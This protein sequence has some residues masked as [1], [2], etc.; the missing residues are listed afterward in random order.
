VVAPELPTATP[1]LV[2]PLPQPLPPTTSLGASTEEIAFFDR[3]RK[4]ISNKAQYGEFLKLINLFT[5]DLCSDKYL[6]YRAQSFIGSSLEL[7]NYFKVFMQYDGSEEIVDNQP[8]NLH[9][10]IQLSNCRGMGP[11]YRL[12]P[13]LEKNKK[14]SGRDALC[15][16]VLN[17]EWVSHP[18]W[19][20]EDSGFVAHRKNAH[21]EGLHRVEEE[22][23]DY[24]FYIEACNRTIQLLEPIAQT[25]NTATPDHRR[26]FQLDPKLGGQSETIYK[27]VVYKIYGRE[28]GN[29]V[30]ENLFNRPYDVVPILLTRLKSKSAEWKAAQIQWERVWRQQTNVLFY[31]S[32][33]HQGVATRVADKRQFWPKQLVNEIQVR[34]QEQKQQRQ[35]RQSSFPTYQ[36]SYSFKD[37]GVLS[38]AARLVLSYADQNFSTD[39]PK[40]VA[41]IKEFLSLFF[42]DERRD[43]SLIFEQE[44]RQSNGSPADGEESLGEDGSSSPRHRANSKKNTLLRGVLDRPR[45]RTGKPENEDSAASDSRGTSPENLSVMDEDNATSPKP[46]DNDVKT[47]SSAK[48]FQHPADSNL[49]NGQTVTPNEQYK[50]QTYNM[51]CNNTIYCFI[52]LFALLYERL[53]KLKANE[54]EVHRIVKR[55]MQPKSAIDLGWIERLPTDFFHDTSE[56]ADYYGQMLETFHKLIKG[57]AE[58]ANIEEALRR[59]YLHDGWQL[60]SLDKLL[61]SLTRFAVAMNTSDA[62]DKSMEIY[63]LFKKDRQR[64]ENTSTQEEFSYRKQ[65]DKH[66][67]EGDV[68]RIAYVSFLVNNLRNARDTDTTQ[69]EKDQVVQIQL[70]K[71]EDPTIETSNLTAAQRWKVYVTAYESLEPT[72]GITY[73]RSLDFPYLRRG[74]R[75]QWGDDIPQVESV[76]D[77]LTSSEN[78][79]FR[80]NHNHSYKID[81]EPSRSE[82]HVYREGKTT[83]AEIDLEATRRGENFQEIFVNNPE[84]MKGQSKD[85]V[86][87]AKQ[88]F[89]DSA[90]NP[91]QLS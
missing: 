52:R 40:I 3:V 51:Y 26:N 44:G 47:I 89:I 38:D 29:E 21:E 41:F 55:A 62:R 56:T 43:E 78:M 77:T 34:Y 68:F 11:S 72:E 27:R 28:K 14:C 76:V 69:D 63:S 31:K 2:P 23:H 30:L 15:N 58:M 66:I 37:S 57:D 80:I 42:L 1:S 87:R 16:S 50:R 24:D 73:A 25:L 39:Y 17:D 54:V 4:H 32:L 9:G 36:F 65:V 64:G 46:Q 12:L 6:I 61:S 90:P 74:V 18:T 85:D 8:K 10:K 81:F 33:D 75:Q 70:I 5:Q 48:W 84:W 71:N 45:G 82:Y 53:A 91:D 20:S 59:Y 19:A 49:V 67:K 13:K 79:V 22:R 86:D 7:M 35:I 88:V 83:R 60:Y